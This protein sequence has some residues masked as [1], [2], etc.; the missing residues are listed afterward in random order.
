[1]NSESMEAKESRISLRSLLF[2]NLAIGLLTFVSNGAALLITMT[3]GAKQLVGKEFEIGIWASLGGIL[4]AAS[5]VGIF[6]KRNPLEIVRL[7]A[8]LIALLAALLAGWGLTLA[9]GK[10]P[11]SRTIWSFGYLTVVSAY[12]AYIVSRAFWESRHSSLR[13]YAKFLFFP[14]CVL[15]D[16]ATFARVGGLF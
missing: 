14:A 9:L 1:M 13:F 10:M 8:A 5:V 7:Q 4:I 3:G 12:A 11:E 2:I 6:R 15:I 16:G